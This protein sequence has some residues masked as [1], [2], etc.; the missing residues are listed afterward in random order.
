MWRMDG[1]TTGTWSSFSKNC[2]TPSCILT[3][4]EAF[5]YIH[6]IWFC[7]AKVRW[8]GNAQPTPTVFV[9]YWFM[10]SKDERHSAVQSCTE[11]SSPACTNWHF[12]LWQ[13]VSRWADFPLPASTNQ[14]YQGHNSCHFTLMP[15]RWN[16]F[17]PLP[18]SCSLCFFFLWIYSASFDFF[19]SL[20]SS[21]PLLLVLHYAS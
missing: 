21:S 6:Q 13:P 5:R 19:L 15:S 7:K 17:I 14:L 20:H 16:S 12:N 11:N 2:E 9:C 10:E 1:W 18:N 4:V 3:I 8:K